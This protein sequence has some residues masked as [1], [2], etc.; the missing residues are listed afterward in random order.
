MPR[1]YF[2]KQSWKRNRMAPATTPAV[3][4]EGSSDCLL[5]QVLCRWAA[6][7]V[8]PEFQAGAYSGNVEKG[9]GG[10][11]RGDEQALHFILFFLRKEQALH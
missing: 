4:L 8:E 2:E 10:D 1:T 11:C 5:N 3:V 9:K 6:L 7:T